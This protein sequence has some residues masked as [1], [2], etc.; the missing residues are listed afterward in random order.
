MQWYWPIWTW[1]YCL[2]CWFTDTSSKCLYQ[3]QHQTAVTL[4]QYSFQ[5]CV[6]I[7]ASFWAYFRKGQ[8]CLCTHQEFLGQLHFWSCCFTTWFTL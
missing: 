2:Q 8:V 7:L 5:F 6:R 4:Q 1:T 3:F